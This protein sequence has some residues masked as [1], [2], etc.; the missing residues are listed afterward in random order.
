M[1]ATFYLVRLC[2][3][4]TSHDMKT[5]IVMRT[6]RSGWCEA[7]IE[8]KPVGVFRKRKG[9]EGRP[10]YTCGSHR[11]SHKHPHVTLHSGREED[12]KAC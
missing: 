12:L 10:D 8:S 2:L 11:N 7:Q 1:N 6:C 5:Y 9:D 3:A 4:V